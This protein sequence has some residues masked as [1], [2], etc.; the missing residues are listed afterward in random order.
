MKKVGLG[1]INVHKLFE[2]RLSVHLQKNVCDRQ[3]MWNIL[4]NFTPLQYQNEWISYFTRHMKIDLYEDL[5][6]VSMRS[7]KPMELE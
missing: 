5:D 7:E 4:P 2:D 1:L 6:N 3:G